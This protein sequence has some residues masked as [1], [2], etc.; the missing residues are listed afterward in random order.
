[1]LGL[2]RRRA[3]AAVLLAT[4]VTASACGGSSSGGTPAAGGS[5]P[6]KVGLVYSKTGLLAA[7][8]KEY[9]QGFQAGLKYATNGTGKVA[10]HTIQVTEQDD[11]G[12][13]AKAV[14]AFK[15]LVGQGYKIIAGTTDSGIALQLAPLAAQNQV[16]YISGPAAADA[17]TGANRYTFRSGRQTYQDV[18]TAAAAVGD[19]Q[20]KQILVFAQD[21]AFGQA[22][23][24]AV[25]SV[26]GGQGATVGT[27]LV[28]LNATD[29]TPFARQV[30]QKRPDLLF[31]AWA[32]ASTPSMWQAMDQQGVFAATKVVTGLANRAA[33]PLYG[34][35]SAKIDFLSYYFYQAPKNAVN[36]WLVRDLATQG[37]KPDLF[38][39]DG[40][41]AAQMIVRAV[42]QAGGDN[43]DKMIG[44]LDGW[45]F[46]APKGQE[47]VRQGDHAMLQPMYVARLTQQAGGYQP[48]LVQT[49]PADRVAPPKK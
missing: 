24:K 34:P 29:F 7:Y 37:Q 35:A 48:T 47:T 3:L 12:D 30:K 41:V 10:G 2:K 5:T 14:S 13:P 36:D 8:G 11:A 44:A 39:P 18:Q 16:L 38:T 6:V 33:Y 45:T 15:G 27:L 9:L 32:G 42:Q 19:V 22:N 28:P 43:V 21:S 23:A 1:M 31:V 40:F 25:K 4:A 26:L 46:Q 49:V 17:I 20:G